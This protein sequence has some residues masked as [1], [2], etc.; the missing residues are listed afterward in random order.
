[1][2]DIIGIGD[3]NIDLIIKVDHIPTHDE[4]VKGKLLG[5]FPGGVIGNFCCAAV[6][7]GV[8]TG[9][10]AKVGNDEY[11]KLC[12]E[13]F[14]RRGV[15][16]RGLV[17]KDNV[18]TYYCIIHLD[19]TGEKALTIVETNGFLPKKDEIDFDY[20]RNARYVHMTSLDVELADYV[21]NQL[22][23][24]GCILSLDIEATAS[25]AGSNTWKNILSKLDIAFPNVAGITALTKT[26]DI[27]EG[28]QF[29]LNRGV[30]M[31]VVT[32][33]AQGVKIY[34][35]NYRYEHPAYKV[36]VK[37][38]TGAGDCFNAVFI[39]CLSKCWPVEK[40]AQYASA[41]AAISIQTVGAREGLPTCDEVTSFLKGRGEIK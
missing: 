38:T 40:S 22:G 29:L 35:K 6:K 7:F 2:L 3:T 36:D 30:K 5:K 10:V 4:K 32:C 28:V 23:G 15:D 9:V 31:V 17:K 1:M 12:V 39:A 8:S 19:H 11:G 14:I 34:K 20:V 18:E 25:K 26:Q 21:F 27:D 24:S 33:G 13:D 37:D 41:A 16:I